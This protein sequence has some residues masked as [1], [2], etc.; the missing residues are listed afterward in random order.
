[1]YERFYLSREEY[2]EMMQDNGKFSYTFR[3]KKNDSENYVTESEVFMRNVTESTFKSLVDEI[4]LYL[5]SATFNIK[6][7]ISVI[8]CRKLGINVE[9]IKFDPDY[10]ITKNNIYRDETLKHSINSETIKKAI[11]KYDRLELLFKNL[12]PDAPINEVCQIVTA[13]LFP[14]QAT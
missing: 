13:M 7:H 1:M 5:D 6:N 11:E 14:G 12:K 9:Y 4:G 8:I 2:F 3:L 10:F